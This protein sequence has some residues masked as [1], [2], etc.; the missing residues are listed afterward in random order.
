M[1]IILPTIAR[2][3]GALALAHFGHLAK[4]SV[5]AKGPL[6]LVTV[7]D[8][9]VEA[10]IVSRLQATFPEDGILGEEGGGI[11]GRSGRVWVIDPIDGTFNF[12]RGGREWSISIGLWDQGRPVFGIVHAPVA[13][14]TLIGGE[15]MAP[16]LNGKPLPMLGDFD[17]AIASVGFGLGG[18]AF[19]LPERIAVLQH[20]KAR[21]GAMVRVCNSAT[22]AMIEVATG[23]TDAYVGYGESAWD[24][25]A[26][27]PILTALGATATL[28]WQQ[29]PLDA[30]LRFVIGKP[31]AVDHCA[32]ALA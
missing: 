17:P 24:V 1:H 30:K 8:R 15:G 18:G 2:E 28:D 25:M 31:G 29:T 32:G 3:A 22:L 6:D 27:W 16:E 20:L 14:M 10:L 13:G 26:I 7:A 9:A 19:P 4:G 11:T 21:A 12:V 5:S 23:E